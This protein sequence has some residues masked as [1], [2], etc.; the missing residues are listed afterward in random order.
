MYCV[1]QFFL[2]GTAAILSVHNILVVFCMFISTGGRV[3]T[4]GM[5]EG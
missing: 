4:S 1:P 3:C 2:S 5:E